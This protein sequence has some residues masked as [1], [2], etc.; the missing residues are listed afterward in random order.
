MLIVTA[1]DPLSC[2]A[3]GAGQCLE[4]FDVLKHVLVNTG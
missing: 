4:E 3:I 1:P 2:V